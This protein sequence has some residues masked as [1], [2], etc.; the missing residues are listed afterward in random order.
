MITDQF[1]YN[2]HGQA[3]INRITRNKTKYLVLT[4]PMRLSSTFNTFFSQNK[5]TKSELGKGCQYL[6]SAS[7]MHQNEYKHAYVWFSGS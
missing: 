2:I 4:P 1:I 7:K 6:E 3:C 5:L